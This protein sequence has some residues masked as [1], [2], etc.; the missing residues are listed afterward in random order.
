MPSEWH[1]PQLNKL[2]EARSKLPQTSLEHFCI[3]I[4]CCISAD[5]YNN[6]DFST[7]GLFISQAHTGLANELN[8]VCDL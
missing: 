1:S 7:I 6:V 2:M 5:M 4:S 8:T 3:D